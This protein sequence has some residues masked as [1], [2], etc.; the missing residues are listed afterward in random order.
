MS[1]VKEKRRYGDTFLTDTKNEYKLCKHCNTQKSL[2]HFGFDKRYN[3]YVS[4]CHE[5]QYKVTIKYRK[6]NR[7]K[8]NANK[9]R[10]N[11]IIRKIPHHKDKIAQMKHRYYM[12]YKKELLIKAAKRHK[13]RYKN[14]INYKILKNMRSRMRTVLK[15][16]SKSE[17]TKKLLGC[18]IKE[19][20]LHLESKF[21]KE[22]SWDNYG[23]DPDNWV[24]DHIICCMVFNFSDSKQQKICFHYS[25]L[26][27]L[28][29][30]DNTIKADFLS[31]GRQARNLSDEEKLIYLR[32]LGHAV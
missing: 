12:K 2:D 14:D 30:K 1:E 16:N 4:K 29:H 19:L 9:R 13:I 3:L 11:K 25:N 22:M 6:N 27:P 32:S 26:Q 8:V 24:I 21:T 7:D 15:N 10:Y 23:K 18:T 5:C 17:S 28:W 20:K 31:D